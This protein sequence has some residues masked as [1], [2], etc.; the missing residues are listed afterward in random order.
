MLVRFVPA[1]VALLLVWVQ[2]PLALTATLGPGFASDYTLTNLGSISGVPTNYGGLT[3]L[4][5]STDT[6]LIG[7]AANFANGTL[8]TV[9]LVRDVGGHIVGFGAS[10]LFGTAPYNDGGLTYGPGGVLFAAQWPI[11]GLAQYKPGSTSPDKVIDLNPLGIAVSLSALSFV[12]SGFSGAGQL[13]FVTYGGGS[14]Y[15]ASFVS[16][17]LG[18]YDITSVVLEATLP[19]GPE[20]FAYVAPGSPGFTTASMIVSEYGAGTV[21]AYDVDS[22]GNPILGSRRDFVTGLSGAEGAFIDPVTGDYLF[23]TFGSGNEVFRV[24]GFTAPN[25]NPGTVPEPST[26]VAFVGLGIVAFVFQ[27]RKSRVA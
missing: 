8:H 9:P 11:N 14:F 5:G 21:G 4:A 17:G 7:G 20:G 12:P 23:S 22:N 25:Q 26:W 18:T 3:F 1:L 27:R 19:G 15:T 13:K 2:G 16:D 24:S 10:S 6:L